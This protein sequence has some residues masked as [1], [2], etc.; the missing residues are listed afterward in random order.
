[1]WDDL[2]PSG[3]KEIEKTHEDTPEYQK[4]DGLARFKILA[5]LLN[6]YFHAKHGTPLYP[7]ETAQ[8]EFHLRSEK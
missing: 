3:G 7:P 2:T 6:T 1:M 8:I 5:D 4:R